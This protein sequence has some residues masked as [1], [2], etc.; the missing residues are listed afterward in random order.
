MEQ[1]AVA[2]RNGRSG[3]SP[4]RGN[5]GPKAAPRRKAPFGEDPTAALRSSD[6]TG[7]GH[8][9][10][11]PMEGRTLTTPRE[12]SSSSTAD[13]QRAARQDAGRRKRR[14]DGAERTASSKKRRRSGGPGHW[15]TRPQGAL[16]REVPRRSAES[17]S[18][19]SARPRRAR[20]EGQR[21]TTRTSVDQT[22]LWPR[23]QWRSGQRP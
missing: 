3:T 6:V 17:S 19:D 15:S 23:S 18:D 12:E 21:S 13:L 8:H 2:G 4:E 11:M 16:E 7:S 20:G 14:R 5:S 10:L 22:A 1:T 9:A